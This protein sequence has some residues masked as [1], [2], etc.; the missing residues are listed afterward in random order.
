M[1]LL[2]TTP[3]PKL[4]APTA[5]PN[6]F[7]PN[8]ALGAVLPDAQRHALFAGTDFGGLWRHQPQVGTED[9]LNG[10]YGAECQRLEFVFTSVQADARQP[11]R[12]VVAGKFRCYNEVTPFRG[13]VYL[14]QVQRL[15]VDV[16]SYY[17]NSSAAAPTYCASGR[18]AVQATS[19][20][21]LGG[22]FTGRVA[23]DFQL[24]PRKKPFL[25][26]GTPNLATRQGGILFDGQWLENAASEPVRAFWKQGIAVTRQILS[27]FEIGLRD[28][29]INPRYARMGWN[30]FWKNDEWWAERKIAKR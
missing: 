9:V 26:A 29:E 10:C 3:P 4:P 25:V 13:S 20:R 23:L 2:G 18:F 30:T 24:D 21:G 16:V 17:N 19:N 28:Q 5:G 27:R 12:Y 15:P 7:A 11:G 22:Q 1:F 14:Q 6:V 8:V